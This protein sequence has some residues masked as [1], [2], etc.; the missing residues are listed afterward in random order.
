MN[1][2]S[3]DE[4]YVTSG[5]VIYSG[6]G[7]TVSTKLVRR[8]GNIS[9]KL[10][11]NFVKSKFQRLERDKIQ[12]TMR[13]LESL[14][15]DAKKIGQFGLYEKLNRLIAKACDRN[16]FKHWV[17]LHTVVEADAKS[18]RQKV[19]EK[20]PIAFGYND[21][22]SDRLYV[23]ASWVDEHCDLTLEKLVGELKTLEKHYEL[24][25]LSEPSAEA[26]LAIK[27]E[28]EDNNQAVSDANPRTYRGIAARLGRL[29]QGGRNLWNRLFS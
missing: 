9:L 10:Y 12:R 18:T 23:I 25:Q 17:V 20:D 29:Q 24:E 2:R 15:I 7:A 4:D 5:N 16:L 13:R 21:Y 8:E 28:F 6:Q 22:D 3:I 14:R 11:F 19:V 27:R 1:Y 26:I